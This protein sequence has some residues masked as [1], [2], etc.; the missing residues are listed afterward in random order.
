MP[1]ANARAPMRQA[2]L[3]TSDLCEITHAE[4]RDQSR[5][6]EPRDPGQFIGEGHDG[7]IRM[8]TGEQSPGPLAEGSIALS[9]LM[10]PQAAFASK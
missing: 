6:K 1:D 10:R 9:D 8:D 7:D 2:A 5:E 4:S 3:Q